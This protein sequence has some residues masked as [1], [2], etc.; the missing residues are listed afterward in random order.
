MISRPASAELFPRGGAGKII[1]RCFTTVAA[2]RRNISPSRTRAHPHTGKIRAKDQSVAYPALRVPLSDETTLFVREPI[3][4]A[5]SSSDRGISCCD[6]ISSRTQ[7]F[8]S[9]PASGRPATAPRARP[10]L[11]DGIPHRRPGR[12]ASSKRVKRTRSNGLG[13]TASRSVWA[14]YVPSSR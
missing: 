1:T 14:R 2:L 12:R 7:Y 11:V 3:R 5:A 13:S 8:K 6:L 9:P 4:A 10:Q